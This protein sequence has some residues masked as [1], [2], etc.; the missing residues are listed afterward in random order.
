MQFF[1]SP[2]VRNSFCPL[3]S[4][5]QAQFRRQHGARGKWPHSSSWEG[6]PL[7]WFSQEPA[8]S[9]TLKKIRSI[10]PESPQEIAHC[11]HSVNIY[12]IN[13]RLVSVH[14]I[15]MYL[16]LTDSEKGRST[17]KWHQLRNTN[18][19]NFEGRKVI[20]Q[21]HRTCIPTYISC[22]YTLSNWRG[23]GRF[24]PTHLISAK[25]F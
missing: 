8:T 19:G 4:D 12:L 21:P 13:I 10:S 20:R 15:S 7:A 22:A 18:P 14:L 16:L 11:R 17:Q 2:Y 23:R 25:S 1:Q 5:V 6:W 24:E 3:G 9:P